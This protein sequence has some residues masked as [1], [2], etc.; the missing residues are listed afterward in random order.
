MEILCGYKVLVIFKSKK[1]KEVFQISK[2]NHTK[3]PDTDYRVYR[4]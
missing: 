2:L 4:R 1:E 3:V